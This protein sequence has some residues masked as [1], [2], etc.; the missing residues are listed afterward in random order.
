MAPR[1]FEMLILS[2][3]ILLTKDLIL[4][5]KDAGSIFFENASIYQII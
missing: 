2:S 4:Q 3:V 1:A 5:S